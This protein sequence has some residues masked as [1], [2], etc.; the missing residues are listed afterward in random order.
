MKTPTAALWRAFPDDLETRLADCMKEAAGRLPSGQHGI[1]FFR[2][3][4]V[5]VPG[6][7]FRRLMTLFMRH[8]TP[9][10]L[11]VVPAWFT[12][13]RWKAIKTIC[14][15]DR[16]LWCW[17]QHGWRH[18]NHE[19]K[20]K[21]QEFGPGRPPDAIRHDLDR[22][23]KRLESILEEDFFPGFTPPWNRCSEETLRLLEEMG[24]SAISRSRG[25]LPG[26]PKGFPDL[27]VH[28]D[29]H[30]RK[31]PD[32]ASGFSGL[33]KEL[34][35]ALSGGLCGIMIHHQLMNDSAFEFLEQL[36]GE[37]AQTDRFLTLNLCDLVKLK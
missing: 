17:H 22:G 7:Q 31:E 21:K 37:L 29:L 12:A 25:A 11:A 23:R 28:V 3:D 36:L 14:E 20:G 18:A 1:V 32:A 15:R 5:G 33:F 2:A 13:A 10:S 8:R 35:R 24:F 34:R 16:S 30:T 26:V 9:L 19:K 27:P 4:D 6:K